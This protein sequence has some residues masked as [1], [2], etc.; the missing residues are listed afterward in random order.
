MKIRMKDVIKLLREK[1]FLKIEKKYD[2]KIIKIKKLMKEKTKL[3]ERKM[4]T[5]AAQPSFVFIG[6]ARTINTLLP[7]V[8]TM[9]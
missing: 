5:W 1:H 9:T 2:W 8:R 7:A 6:A 4:N 3:K